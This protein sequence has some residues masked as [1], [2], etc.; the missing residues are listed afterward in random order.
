MII[1]PQQSID[2]NQQII[3]VIYKHP[4]ITVENDGVDE[5]LDQL[6]PNFKDLFP[7]LNS[8]WPY[9]RKQYISL[10]TQCLPSKLNTLKQSLQHSNNVYSLNLHDALII[11]IRCKCFFLFIGREPTTW[12][13]NNCLQ[14]M[15]KQLLNSII[16]KYR[17]LSVSRRSIICLSL[18]LREIIDLL[19]TDRSRYFAQPHP[20]IA[21]YLEIPIVSWLLNR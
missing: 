1:L 3:L 8:A 21:N 2:L 5:K 19:A 6:S 14:I 11:I 17:D 12:P 10:R 9:I 20:I 13:T 18:R 7:K 4:F 15:I 16:A